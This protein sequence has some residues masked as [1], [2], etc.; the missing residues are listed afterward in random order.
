MCRRRTGSMPLQRTARPRQEAAHGEVTGWK[1]Q[2]V[3]P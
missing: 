2:E 1:M 3:S